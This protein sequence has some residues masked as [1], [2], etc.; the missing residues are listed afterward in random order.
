MEK[1]QIAMR[2]YRKRRFVQGAC[3][4]VYQR[5]IAGVN[6]FYDDEDYLVYISIVSVLRK[7][8]N[9]TSLEIC[10]MRNHVHLLIAA[11][12]L[13]DI[14]SFVRHYTSLF[15]TEFNRDIGRTG[16]LFH[17]SFGS[18]PKSGNKKIRSAIVYIGNNPVEKFMCSEASK[19]RWNF[20]AYLESRTP[21]SAAVPFKNTSHRYQMAVAEVK[22][23][24]R[25]NRHLS[26]P[27]VR[28]LLYSVPVSEKDLLI[29]FIISSYKVLDGDI[30]LS[31]YNSFDE[32]LLAMKS[33][34]GSEYDIKEQYDPNSDAVYDDMV[35]FVIEKLGVVPARS[36]I[37]MPFDRKMDIA[38]ALRGHTSATLMQISR[39]LHLD[40]Q[41]WTESK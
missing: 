2:K 33:T 8:Y 40:V 19:Y 37:S 7:V 12:N 34:S 35:R 30:L 20:L 26:Y 14:S 1:T 9:V 41:K 31:Y 29:D 4:H 36:V 27:Q 11:D 10:I 23:M 3:M 22:D 24:I 32:M 17:K 21:F 25:G 6:V 15:V 5:S 38:N 28:R 13:D 18:A 39:F 16:P